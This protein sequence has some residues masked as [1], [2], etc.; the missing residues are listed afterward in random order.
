MKPVGFFV[1]ACLVLALGQLAA[2]LLTLVLAVLCVWT[3]CFHTKQVLVVVAALLLA[4]LLATYPG[5][6]VALLAVVGFGRWLGRTEP[7]PPDQRLL[8]SPSQDQPHR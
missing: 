2:T 5:W 7:R 6:S 1:A 4:Y 3:V 8:P